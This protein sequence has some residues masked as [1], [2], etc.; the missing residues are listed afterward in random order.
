MKRLMTMCL[1]LSLS[2]V[3]TADG[4]YKEYSEYAAEVVELAQGS[5]KNCAEYAAAIPNIGVYRD[6]TTYQSVET[7]IHYGMKKGT[8][9][10][11]KLTSTYA[12]KL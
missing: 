9:R 7:T 10:H 2:T 3:T 11:N 4:V 6:D 1:L 12:I 5:L 8:C